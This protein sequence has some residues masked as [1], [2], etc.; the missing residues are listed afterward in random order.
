MSGHYK[1]L[2][3]RLFIF[4]DDIRKRKIETQIM[5]KFK[6]IKESGS[7]PKKE[8][9][10]CKVIRGHKKLLRNIMDSKLPVKG[11]AKFNNKDKTQ[12]RYYR[13]FQDHYADNT[14]EL[15]FVSK[16]DS[17]PLTDGKAKRSDPKKVK[18]AESSFNNSFCKEYFSTQA[19]R[20]SFFLFIELAF[21]SLD[22]EDLKKKF[23]FKC[24]EM[25]IHTLICIDK[26]LILKFYLQDEIFKTLELT[27]PQ[28]SFELSRN[29]P[30][31]IAIGELIEIGSEDNDETMADLESAIHYIKTEGK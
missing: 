22:P 30:S 19:V 12:L 15:D 13:L 5:K 8:Y 24:C 31:I 18:D 6:S 4:K 21:S 25:T 10:R 3:K 7:H 9:V 2:D 11:I 1:K 16:T 14:Y 17:G 29:L 28:G 23:G 27:K 26:W 20:E